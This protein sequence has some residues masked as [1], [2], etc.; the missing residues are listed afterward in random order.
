VVENS[1]KQVGTIAQPWSANKPQNMKPCGRCYIAKTVSLCDIFSTLQHV[2]HGDIMKSN[3][4]GF[5]LIEVI[6]VAAI[7]A[8][9]AGILV[10]MIYN[11][12]D[13]AKVYL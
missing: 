2:Q 13:T 5:T 12:I 11:Q 6:V 4:H 8:I 9:L 3:C 1:Q 10:P 7:I